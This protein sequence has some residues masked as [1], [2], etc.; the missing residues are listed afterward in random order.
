MVAEPDFLRIYNISLVE[1]CGFCKDRGRLPTMKS[2]IGLAMVLLAFADPATLLAQGQF[3]NAGAT[4]VTESIT[5]N[6][7][8]ESGESVTVRLALKNVGEYAVSN[9]VAAIQS[10]NGVSDPDPLSQN[11]GVLLPWGP[12]VA[13]DFSFRATGASNS[14]IFINLDL[15]ESGA[16]LGTVTF[17]F[18]IGPQ[19]NTV[20]STNSIHLNPVGAAAP[21]PSI[22][23]ITNVPGSIIGVN[24]TFSNLSHIFPDDLDILLVSPSGDAVVVMSDAG[25]GVALENRT[26]TLADGAGNPLPD[27]GGLPALAVFRPTNYGIGDPFPSPA[28]LGPHAGVFSAFNG[29]N[30]NGDWKLFI[31]DDSGGDD[32]D[33]EDGWALTIHTLQPVEPGPIL[34]NLG[35]TTNNMI[36]FAVSG[37]PGHSY[38]IETSPDPVQAFP[39]QKF[40]MPASGTKTF[41]FP[42]SLEDKFFRAATDP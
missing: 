13:K 11:Y 26:F 12:S 3:R 29:K 23:S 9:L 19:I 35:R 33:L 2:A 38:A 40:I 5:T 24:L 21:Y 37:R 30:A 14:L 25:G 32:G 15:T 10:V 27:T 1:E 42:L 18:R 39:F 34:T 6:N 7:V 16:G 8:I 20:A 28:P 17:R 36:R 22:L 41:E 4:L 31:T